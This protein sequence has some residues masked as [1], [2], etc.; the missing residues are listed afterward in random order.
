MK[1]LLPALAPFLLVAL[2][3]AAPAAEGSAKT[4]PQYRTKK[5]CRVQQTIGSRLAGTSI[6]RT[7]AEWDELKAQSRRTT[8]RIQDSTAACLRGPVCGN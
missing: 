2:A 3:G 6:C 8:E 4:D 7:R 5:I 1:L